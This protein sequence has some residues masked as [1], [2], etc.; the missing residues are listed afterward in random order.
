VNQLSFHVGDCE[1]IPMADN[2]VDLVMC[3][4]PYEDARTYGI[5]FKLKGDE[6]V[7]WAVP[8]F[9]ECLRVCKGLVAWVVEG[10]T[11]KF[12][13]SATP[14]RLMVALQDAGAK[15]RKPPVY[16]RV[17]IPGSGGP[18]WL[19]N[20]YELIV[21][22]T[23]K[24]KL[25]WSDNTACG[26][27]PKWAPGGE[28]SHRLSDGSRKNQWGASS[29]ST[30]GERGQDGKLKLV[31]EKPSHKFTTKAEHTKRR[32]SGEMETQ[33]YE[34]PAIAN[35]GN[36]IHCKVGGGLMGHQLA[37]E[38][39]AAFPLSL[40]EFFVQSFCP[41]GGVVLDPFSGSGT[42]AHA[43][44]LHGRSL[45]MM[46][47]RMSQIELTLKRVADVIKQRPEDTVQAGQ[48]GEDVN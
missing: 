36:V 5:D 10:K 4:P 15:L 27:P 26:H 8:R 6:W 31:K 2:S 1:K 39:E 38:N 40:A 17:G 3:S 20:D 48:G 46:D 23:K 34:A 45:V 9:M 18:D 47:I 25:P 44:I 29:K 16:H 12:E 24:G 21:C 11:R 35:P 30:G 33:E 14:M 7:Q 32:E 42:T 19:R 13:Y 37:H 41:P 22:A 43:A 28:M